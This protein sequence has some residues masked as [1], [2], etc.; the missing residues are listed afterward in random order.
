LGYQGQLEKQQWQLNLRRDK[1]SD[2]GDAST[3]YA[4]YAYY[5]SPTWRLKASASKGFMAPTF[6]DLYYPRTWGGN[7]YL[8]PETARSNEVG[9]QYTQTQWNARLTVFENRYIDLIVSDIDAFST[10]TNILKAKN[11]GLEMAFS[12]N[13]KIPEWGTQ[14]WRLSMTSQDPKNEI[15]NQALARRAKTLVQAGLMQSLGYWDFGTQMRYTG[16]K[17]DILY[18]DIVKNLASSTVLDLTASRTLTPDLRLNLRVE[19]ATNENYQSIYGYNMPK[20][21]LFVGLRWAPAR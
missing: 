3:W 8:R 17:I 5:L 18:P 7:P 19:N 2:F 9:M 12:G 1:Y 6:N 20:R 13:W 11:Q 4:G 15:T 10:R 21:G 14:H 16:S